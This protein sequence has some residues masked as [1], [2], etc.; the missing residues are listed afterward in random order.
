[1]S[2]TINQILN[3]SESDTHEINENLCFNTEL[4]EKCKKGPHI[5]SILKGYGKAVY[6]HPVLIDIRKIHD[7]SYIA[8]KTDPSKDLPRGFQTRA[9]QDI[10][11]DVVDEIAMDMSNKNWDPLKLQGAVF[12]LPEEYRGQSFSSDGVERIYGIANLT[13]RLY[14][15]K[16]SGQTH[17]IAWVID[18]SLS[19]L[20]KWATAEAN[21]HL[22]AFNERKEV[23]IIQSILMDINDNNSDL[24]S[25][26]EKAST[27]DKQEDIIREEVETYHVH[28]KTRDSIV[29]RLAFKGAYTPDRKK[30]DAS[31]MEE[32]VNDAYSEWLK[33]DNPLYDYI[34]ENDVPVIIA[35]D[36]GRGSIEVAEKWA[37]HV[38][39]EDGNGPLRVL[40]SLKK[41][42]KITKSEANKIRRMFSVKV[43]DHIKLFGKAYHKI[44]VEHQGSLPMYT[45]FHEFAGETKPIDLF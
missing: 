45:A 37:K 1:M 14:G 26:I 7:L 32:Y 27:P 24:H 43:G 19:K 10:D 33:S 20:R 11:P 3:I 30:W 38:L 8:H 15:A 25:A 44:Y 17:I 28:S 42:G 31:F 23:D 40:F 36:E 22:H 29:R 2:P 41:S 35:Q 18:I 21:R 34:S 16:Q 5:N 12:L 4:F 6:P 39:D 9:D 13:H